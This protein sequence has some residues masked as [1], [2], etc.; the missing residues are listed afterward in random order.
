MYNKASCCVCVLFPDSVYGVRVLLVELIGHE[1][2]RVE[3]ARLH[4]RTRLEV[5]QTLRFRQLVPHG[6][7]HHRT[8]VP[9]ARLTSQVDL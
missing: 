2:E 7:T 8:R 4:R 1:V 5:L 6:L 9:V 3:V